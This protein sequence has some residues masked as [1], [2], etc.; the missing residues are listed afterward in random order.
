MKFKIKLLAV[1]FLLW[2]QVHAPILFPL[3]DRVLHP[4]GICIGH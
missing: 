3:L 4:F 2:T 1:R